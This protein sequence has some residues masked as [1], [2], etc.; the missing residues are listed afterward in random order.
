[1]QGV[2][3]IT[4]RSISSH[5]DSQMGRSEQ[6]GNSIIWRRECPLNVRRTSF[7]RVSIA[8]TNPLL[9]TSAVHGR[10]IA[11][12]AI[13]SNLGDR[14]Q[15]IELG[16]RYL[17]DYVRAFPSSEDLGNITGDLCVVNTSFLYETAPMY[18]IDQPSFINCACLV[19]LQM[20]K[21]GLVN[22]NTS[23]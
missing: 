18:V 15:N 11:C 17:D 22:N 19:S 4:S 7:E 2:Y 20:H 23:G 21:H 6:V 9:R 14:F 12:L 10:T 3:S 8:S 5:S 16:L 13:G 1:M